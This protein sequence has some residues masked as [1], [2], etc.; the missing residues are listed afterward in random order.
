MYLLPRFRC[1]ILKPYT[2]FLIDKKP[3]ES[4]TQDDREGSFRKNKY[5]PNVNT[6]QSNDKRPFAHGV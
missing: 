6:I 5:K 4:T 2:C 3:E 1:Y